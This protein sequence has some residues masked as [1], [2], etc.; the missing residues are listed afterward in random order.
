MSIKEMFYFGL[1]LVLAI[2]LGGVCGVFVGPVL[3]MLITQ[4]WYDSAEGGFI[5]FCYG[6]YVGPVIGA[7]LGAALGWWLWAL[8]AASPRQA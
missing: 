2:V 1:C 4:W 3:G 5:G 8:G 6:V 7:L